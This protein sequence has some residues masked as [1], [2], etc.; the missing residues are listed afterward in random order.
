MAPA[1]GRPSVAGR[2]LLVIGLCAGACARRAAPTP[3]RA[4][5]TAAAAPVATT[6]PATT[7]TSGKRTAGADDDN[8]RPLRRCFGELPPWIDPPVTDVLD[9]ASRFLEDEDFEGVLACTEE[10]ARGS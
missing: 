1:S 9:Q 6:A 3:P 10:A 2:L 4:A 8:I 7:S 5:G